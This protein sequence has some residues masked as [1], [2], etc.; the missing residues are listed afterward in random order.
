MG[1]VKKQ[2]AKKKKK[3]LI[4]L[5]TL[6]VWTNTKEVQKIIKLTI[7]V[8]KSKRTLTPLFIFS[9]SFSPSHGSF[10]L[11]VTL[12]DSL[13]LLP[14]S[15]LSFSLTFL[16]SLYRGLC[17]GVVVW[18]SSFGEFWCGSMLV[19]FCVYR[20]WFLWSLSSNIMLWLSSGSWI[21][22]WVGGGGLW[23]WFGSAA[24]VCDYGLDRRWRFV[25]FDL[26]R[27][28]GFALVWVKVLWVA[29]NGSWRLQDPNLAELVVMG[30]GF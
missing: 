29:M 26:D 14:L 15:N 7:S 24:V 12:F 30:M 6:K 3:R 9:F 8:L 2:K 20:C 17:D 11:L 19:G 23:F 18:V 25:D 1:H 28:G 22:M 21:L 4:L 5:T 16:S 10:F 27:R 13:I